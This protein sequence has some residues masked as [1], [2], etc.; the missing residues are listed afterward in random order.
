MRKL[1]N[2][3][4]YINLYRG[5]SG[6]L[7]FIYLQRKHCILTRVGAH[8][9]PS[10]KSLIHDQHPSIR[11]HFRHECERTRDAEAGHTTHTDL[12]FSKIIQK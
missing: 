7:V 8:S 6:T 11:Q 1:Y 4:I 2:I 10:L 12:L 3:Y 9:E 5:D